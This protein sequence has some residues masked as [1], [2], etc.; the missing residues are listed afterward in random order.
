MSYLQYINSFDGIIS[1][2]RFI[3][4][5]SDRTCTVKEVLDSIL[6]VAILDMSVLSV[7][8]LQEAEQA[9]CCQVNL[10]SDDFL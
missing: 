3:R 10:L 6:V 2:M 1:N 5:Q 9:S 7:F 4:S 8:L